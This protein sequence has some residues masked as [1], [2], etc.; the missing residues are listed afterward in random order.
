MSTV[1]AMPSVQPESMTSSPSL[2]PLAPT[3]PEFNEKIAMLAS[4]LLV[5][6][7]R[8]S[9]GGQDVGLHFRAEFY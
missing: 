5:G 2:A 6:R 8:L 7:Q 3:I 1:L 4:S 9:R